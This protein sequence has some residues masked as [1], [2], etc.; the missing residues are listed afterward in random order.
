MTRA[1]EPS[2]MSLWRTAC[3]RSGLP[4]LLVFMVACGGGGDPFADD[5]DGGT[6]GVDAAGPGPGD[7][8]GGGGGAADAGMQRAC[9]PKPKRLVVLGD[10]ITDCSVI[11]GPNDPDC[12]SRL[13]YDYVKT[14]FA[15]DLA[16][17]PHA[18]GG[19]TTNGIAQQLA[20]VQGGPG[21]VLV[22]IYIG[23][24]DLAPYIFQSDSAAMS[25]Y[26]Q[27]LPGIV[28]DWAD[29]FSFF[30]DEAK[31]PDGV[32]VV[33]NS[34]YNPFDDCTASPYNLSALKINLLHMFNAV[35]VDMANEHFDNTLLIDQFTP[36]LGHGHH[37]NVASCPHYVAGA[38]G[39]MQDLIHANAE[40]NKALAEQL[41]HGADLLYE[42]CEP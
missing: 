36:F 27:M 26:T 29:F 3:R 23:G 8:D 37:Y 39:Y 34:Q 28:S 15:E 38:K 16:Y 7:P 33:M 6:G 35:L 12:V 25:G 20:N 18:V 9:A 13:F 14:N 40:G 17:E 32:T 42:D 5:G 2:F 1:S 22:M 24:N 10:S 41:N 19:A 31:F 4:Y 11:G 30:S 21:H